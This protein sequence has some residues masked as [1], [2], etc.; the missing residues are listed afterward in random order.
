MFALCLGLRSRF[1][2]SGMVNGPDET[3]TPPRQRFYESWIVRRIA[4]RLAYLVDSSI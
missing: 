4:K 3:V 2:H 1:G